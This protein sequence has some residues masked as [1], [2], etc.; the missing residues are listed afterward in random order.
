MA[1]KYSEKMESLV[2]YIRPLR[3]KGFKYEIYRYSFEEIRLFAED[4]L[5]VRLYA[6]VFKRD[7]H[8]I[9]FYIYPSFDKYRIF[10]YECKHFTYFNEDIEYDIEPA[11]RTE[12]TLIDL[13]DLESIIFEGYAKN[14]ALIS[15]RINSSFSDIVINFNN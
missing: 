2:S 9:R 13:K 5:S 11:S 8:Y 15:L 3:G 6:D 7:E 1:T 4:M 14:Y 12:F 10:I